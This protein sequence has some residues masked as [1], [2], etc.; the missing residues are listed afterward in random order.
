M[1]MLMLLCLAAATHRYEADHDELPITT[2]V[3]PPN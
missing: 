1:L 3:P 2:K